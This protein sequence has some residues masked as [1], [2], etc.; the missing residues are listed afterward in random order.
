MI[1]MP[2][3]YEPMTIRLLEIGVDLLMRYF[4]HSR[5]DAEKLTSAFLLRDQSVFNEDFI[6]HEMPWRVAAAIHYLEGLRGSRERLGHWLIESGY[7]NSPPEVPEF[8][9]ARMRDV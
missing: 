4:G 5:E 1:S 7:Q 6:H 9:R 3:D 2:S 8:V